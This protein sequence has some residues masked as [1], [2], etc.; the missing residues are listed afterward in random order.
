MAIGYT[1]TQY[2]TDIANAIREKTK[3]TNSMKPSEMAPA[4][5]SIK[6]GGSTEGITDPEKLYELTRPDDWLTMPT[7]SEINDNELYLLF[8]IP[9]GLSAPIAFS[10]NC[11]GS[12][13]V[14]L[15]TSESRTQ[16]SSTTVSSG[17]TYSAELS[18]SDFGD[19]TSDGMKQALIKVSGTDITSWEVKETVGKYYKTCSWN[20][21]ETAGKLTKLTSFKCYNKDASNNITTN[22]D[23]GLG[24]LKYFSLYGSNQLQSSANMFNYCKSLILVKQLDTSNFTDM[25]YLFEQC[26]SLQAIPQFNTSNV[27]NMSYMFYF[28][29]Y[30]AASFN[31]NLS[32]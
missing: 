13:T 16:V 9:N 8:H 6:S 15:L 26:D 5:L 12:Y 7:E 20:I 30:T 18:S 11:T 24:K 17:T 23:R 31:L 25:S 32:N 21:V 19:L 2:Y 28:A 1:N 3:T 14:S 10:V 29:G 4:I 22:L 27:V